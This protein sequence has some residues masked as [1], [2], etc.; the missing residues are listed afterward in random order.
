MPSHHIAS[1][2][3]IIHHFASTKAMEKMGISPLASAK[4]L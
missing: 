2:H 1:R 3:H 4:D